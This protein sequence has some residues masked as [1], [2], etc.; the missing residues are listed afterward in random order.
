MKEKNLLKIKFIF[1]LLT[2]FSILYF[3]IFD[4]S[5][6][7]SGSVY[8]FTLFFV[9]I[10]FVFSILYLKKLLAEMKYDIDEKKQKE[11][12]VRDCYQYLQLLNP[13]DVNN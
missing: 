12:N 4:L 6:Y 1:L 7:F 10:V 9:F 3:A 2:S 8:Y 13:P 11:K 5:N